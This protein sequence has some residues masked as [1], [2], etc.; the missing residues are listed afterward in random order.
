MLSSSP[1]LSPPTSMAPGTLDREDRENDG[2]QLC[3]SDS[4][5]C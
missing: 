4:M 1:S 5:N 2:E 3:I